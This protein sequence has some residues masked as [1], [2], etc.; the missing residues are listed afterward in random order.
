MRR[1]LIEPHVLD[2]PRLEEHPD[3]V[4][5]SSIERN[6]RKVGAASAKKI[7]GFFTFQEG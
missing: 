5:Q 1:D 2:K 7:V 4:E 6:G 3:A